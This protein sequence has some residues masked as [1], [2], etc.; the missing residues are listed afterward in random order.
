MAIKTCYRSLSGSGEREMT[1]QEFKK[2]V[3]KFDADEDG[4]ISKNELR[5]AIRATGGWFSGRKSK[6]GM[7]SA[8]ANGNGFI[9]G[10]EIHNLVEFAKK[11][12]HVKIVDY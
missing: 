9:E 8:D 10:N 2:W 7:Q 6:Q 4:R 3:R 1:M 11:Q 5:D 12:L